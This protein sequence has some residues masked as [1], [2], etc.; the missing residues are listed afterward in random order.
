MQSKDCLIIN[1]HIR[2]IEF[3]T[4]LVSTLIDEKH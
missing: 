2:G 3:L 4:Y 1:D